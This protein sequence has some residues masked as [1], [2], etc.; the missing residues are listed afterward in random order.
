MGGKEEVVGEEVV[1]GYKDETDFSSSGF[2]ETSFIISGMVEAP[3][4]P[5]ITIITRGTKQPPTRQPAIKV[6]QAKPGFLTTTVGVVGEVGAVESLGIEIN[7]EVFVR[8]VKS[9]ISVDS[10]TA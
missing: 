6:L 4:M 2:L 3:A 9:S 8:G 10:K 1:E 7:V 5:I